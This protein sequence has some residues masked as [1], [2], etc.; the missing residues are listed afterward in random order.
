MYVKYTELLLTNQLGQVIYKSHLDSNTELH[1][2]EQGH[3]KAGIY[4]LQVTGNGNTV[5]EKVI[6]Y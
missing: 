3:C 4:Y 6:V 2:I 5:S 1:Q